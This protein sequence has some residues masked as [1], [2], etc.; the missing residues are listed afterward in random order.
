MTEHEVEHVANQIGQQHN[1]DGKV[2]LHRPEHKVNAQEQL[3]Q[4][5]ANPHQ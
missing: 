3:A 1:P 2:W 5:F 4:E